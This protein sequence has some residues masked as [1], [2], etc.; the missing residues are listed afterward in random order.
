LKIVV[1]VIMDWKEIFK[2]KTLIRLTTL[3]AYLD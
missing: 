3:K 2:K 1:L